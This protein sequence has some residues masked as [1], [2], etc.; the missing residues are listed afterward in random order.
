MASFLLSERRGRLGNGDGKLDGS[1][2]TPGEASGL[3]GESRGGEVIANKTAWGERGLHSRIA[4]GEVKWDEVL[5]IASFRTSKG[6]K[7][8]NGMCKTRATI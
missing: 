2:D 5:L 8:G 3:E 6:P 7:G 1:G 4:I